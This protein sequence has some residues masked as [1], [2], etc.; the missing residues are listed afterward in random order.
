MMQFLEK[1]IES[2]GWIL[3]ILVSLLLWGLF[4]KGVGLC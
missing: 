2:S 4:L 1:A 3:A